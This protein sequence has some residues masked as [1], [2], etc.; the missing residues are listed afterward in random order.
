M[1]SFI[2][3]VAIP[4]FLTRTTNAYAIHLSTISDRNNLNERFNSVGGVA[5]EVLP[6]PFVVR[7]VSSTAAAAATTTAT[8]SPS[9]TAIAPPLETNPTETAPAPTSTIA[10]PPAVPN[11]TQASFNKK[12]AILVGVGFVVFVGLVMILHRLYR[13]YFP[14]Q[15]KPVPVLPPTVGELRDCWRVQEMLK[16]WETRNM[17]PTDAELWRNWEMHGRMYRAAR[18]PGGY[19]NNAGGCG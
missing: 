6:V 11:N 1:R 9:S 16:M 4:Y 18:Q 10:P 3:L 14:K 5:L 8:T 12:D 19:D 15:Y 2:L 7:Q 17:D 13:R